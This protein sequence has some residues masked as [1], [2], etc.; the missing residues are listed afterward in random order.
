MNEYNIYIR[1]RIYLNFSNQ[2]D[3]FVKNK[4]K[5]SRPFCKCVSERHASIIIVYLW[6]VCLYVCIYFIFYM[7]FKNL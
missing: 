7:V 1:R 3:T 5:M 6:C 2:K 4:N